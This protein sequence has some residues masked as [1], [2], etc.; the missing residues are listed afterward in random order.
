MEPVAGLGRDAQGKRSDTSGK[1]LEGGV[2]AW[3][4]GIQGVALD[5]PTPPCPA[6]HCPSLRRSPLPYRGRRG[7]LQLGALDARR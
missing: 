6:L 1:Q 3:M 7:A 5:Q 2:V 4:Q